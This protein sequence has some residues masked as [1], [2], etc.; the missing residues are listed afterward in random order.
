MYTMTTD[1][2]ND[3]YNASSGDII[4]AFVSINATVHFYY[5]LLNSLARSTYKNYAIKLSKNENPDKS[6]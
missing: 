3:T 1:I 2:S 6:K 4:K 5:F